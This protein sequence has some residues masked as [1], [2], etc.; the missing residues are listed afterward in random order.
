MRLFKRPGSDKYY[1]DL[2]SYGKLSAWS[3]GLSDYR[4]AEREAFAYLAKM[5]LKPK[6]KVALM[7][8][9]QRYLVLSKSNKSKEA[10]NVDRRALELLQE[11]LG[12]DILALEITRDKM[13]AF[14]ASLYTT[15]AKRG[16]SAVLQPSSID[17]YLNTIRAFFLWCIEQEVIEKSPM[18]FVKG[19]RITKKLPK[20][21]EWTELQAIFKHSTPYQR[22]I[23]LLYLCG[24]NR[25]A[26]I[27]NRLE[28]AEIKKD[29]GVIDRSKEGQEK[30]IIMTKIMKQILSKLPRVSKYVLPHAP[31]TVGR[32]FNRV[33]KKAGIK[34]GRLH[35]LRDTFAT[36][37]LNTGEMDLKTLAGILNHA[38]TRMTEGYAK[39]MIRTKKKAMEKINFGSL[40]PKAKKIQKPAVKIHRDSMGRITTHN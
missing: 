9:A 8:L 7:D 32:W 4:E 16:S 22:L 21:F 36:L 35:R 17:R 38:D 1:L 10:H 13:E 11:N 2:R 5:N 12:R 40:L 14:V 39:L 6:G 28:W 34:G 24:G 33:C 37:A 3:T 20:P 31:G 27:A 29:Y 26:E 19:P 25:R 18:R 15:R 23:W 30:I